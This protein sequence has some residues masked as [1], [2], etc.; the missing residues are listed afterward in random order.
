M[1]EVKETAKRLFFDYYVPKYSNLPASQL[2]FP[3]SELFSWLE[4]QWENYTGREFIFND[5]ETAFINYD[6]REDVIVIFQAVVI[7][8]PDYLLLLK[9]L[10]EATGAKNIITT[11]RKSN[12][13]LLS[14]LS[15]VYGFE[16]T[17][18]LVQGY[19]NQHYIGLN[20]SAEK[21]DKLTT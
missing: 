13:I 15:K 2:E 18:T 4:K 3:Q 5:D 21:F 8:P 6:D 12:K 10:K 11:V 1:T 17:E 14:G 19:S 20:L 7:D 9:R 16:I